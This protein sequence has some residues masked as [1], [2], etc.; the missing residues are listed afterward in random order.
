MKS[1]RRL[2]RPKCLFYFG[3]ALALTT[4][5]CAR[6]QEAL[7]KISWDAAAKIASATAL[8]H[9]QI[10]PAPAGKGGKILKISN[11]GSAP[12]QVTVLTIAK[13]HVT[14][15]FYGLRGQ[16]RYEDVSGDGYLEMWNDFPGGGHYFAR[17][18]LPAGPMGKLSGTSDWREL[19]LPFNSAGAGAHPD[20]LTINVV[21]PGHGTVFLTP[22][23]LFEVKPKKSF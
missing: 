4:Q 17:T 18:L 14:S 16:V 15:D 10:L 9:E 7:A 11:P 5:P 1:L 19:L 13:P 2:A 20:R 12:L 22:L 8:A 23:E 6:A 3:V 21:L